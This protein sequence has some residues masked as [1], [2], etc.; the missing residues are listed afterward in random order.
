MTIGEFLMT[1]IRGAIATT[2]D[3]ADIQAI[4]L[5]NL[6]DLKRIGEAYKEYQDKIIEF[7]KNPRGVEEKRRGFFNKI[8]DTAGKVLKNG[9]AEAIKKK[10]NFKEGDGMLLKSLRAAFP[11]I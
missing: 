4:T 8:K 5:K 10:L 3:D 9:R 6:E 11:A 2:I 1:Q 7:R